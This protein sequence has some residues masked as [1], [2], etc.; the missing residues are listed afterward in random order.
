MKLGPAAGQP[1]PADR[2]AAETRAQRETPRQTLSPAAAFPSEK[3]EEEKLGNTYTIQYVS[4]D[5]K[6]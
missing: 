6:F 4:A 3:E 1:S 2:R 5:G